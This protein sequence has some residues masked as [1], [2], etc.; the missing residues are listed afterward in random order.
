LLLM[1]VALIPL[2]LIID[3]ALLYAS[4]PDAPRYVGIIDVPIL[5]VVSVA[6]VLSRMRKTQSVEQKA[7]PP[8]SALDKLRER[9][10]GRR[11]PT[12]SAK[13]ILD[14]HE[15]EE[16]EVFLETPDVEKRSQDIDET[17]QRM[18]ARDMNLG[19]GPD[20]EIEARPQ[21]II[22][23]P[24][25]SAERVTLESETRPKGKIKNYVFSPAK[26]KVPAFVCR[27]GHPHRF[28]CLT[29]GLTAEQA[30]KKSKMHW[31]EWIPEMG[32]LP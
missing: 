1:I 4:F 23:K 3:F 25:P 18:K 12:R 9:N 19:V 21:P 11:A 28:V 22:V 27:C 24:E 13:P 17:L 7:V 31:V 30:A 29:C 6:F 16:A 5:V 26:L 14:R 10:G 2:A 8:T 32:A 15:E 20:P